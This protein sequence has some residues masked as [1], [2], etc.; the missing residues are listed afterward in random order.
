MQSCYILR[1]TKNWKYN[2]VVDVESAK[3]LERM[4]NSTFYLTYTDF[5]RSL[6][7]IREENCKYNKFNKCV[8]IFD[9]ELH[10]LCNSNNN[11]LF[12]TDDDD[13]FHDDVIDIIMSKIDHIHVVRW[14]YTKLVNIKLVKNLSFNGTI[15]TRPMHYQT[16]NYCIKSPCEITAIQHDGAENIFKNSPHE[17]FLDENLSIHNKTIA[18]RSYWCKNNPITQIKLIEGAD[19][20]NLEIDKDIPKTF[21][22]Y[23]DMLYDL[24]S[25]LKIRPFLI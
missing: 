13:W 3:L 8:E 12:P 10:T 14:R 18:S 7:K 17:I 16:N 9:D 11:L 24:M 23:I 19:I 2:F 4:W 21:H 15:W 25:K 22:K 20:K 1:R 6:N 5:R